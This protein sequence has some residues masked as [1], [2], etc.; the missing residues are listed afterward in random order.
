MK[1]ALNKWFNLPRLGKDTFSDLMKAK[2]KYDTK[3][4]FQFTSSTNIPRALSVLSSA[5]GEEVDVAKSC[6]VCDSTLGED[7]PQDANICTSCQKNE[8]AYEL[9]VMKFAKL[10]ETV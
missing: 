8:D 6:F 9:Y 10:M 7:A 3:F 1:I 2:V 5:L 4:G